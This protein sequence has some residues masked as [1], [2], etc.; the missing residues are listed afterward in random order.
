MSAPRCGCEWISA[1]SSSVRLVPVSVWSGNVNLP[2]SCSSPAVCTSSCSRAESPAA[3]AVALAKRAT[4]AEWRA[5]M[6]SRMPSVSTITRITPL[7]SASSSSTCSRSSS[8]WRCASTTDS[9]Q[10]AVG[11]QHHGEHR[12]RDQADLLVGEHRAGRQR[13]GRDLPREH[14]QVEPAHR[15]EQARA[16]AQAEVADDQQEV[17]E[18]RREV[19]AEDDRRGR[20]LRR[21]SVAPGRRAPRTAARRPPGRSSAPRRC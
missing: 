2:T 21:S 13:A 5:V 6:R 9:E 16:V 1:Q 20:E 19:D 14:R 10:V 11:E 8:R 18:V 3:A 4:A 17:E 12:D 15:V 7:C